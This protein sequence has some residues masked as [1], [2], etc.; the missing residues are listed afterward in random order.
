MATD[1]H[2]GASPEMFRRAKLLREVLT[3][4]ETR[5]W[6]YLRANQLRGYRF[7]SQHPIHTFVADFYCHTARLIVELDGDV[8]DSTE[9]INHDKNRTFVLEDFGLTIVRFR[10]ER[11]FLDI[12]RVLSEIATHLPKIPPT[13][14]HGVTPNPLK[15]A[16]S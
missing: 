15:G 1:M 10:N 7:K 11:I 4:A 3:P 8:H 16:F 5:L 13:Y 12:D 14:P 6:A 2:F 9:Q